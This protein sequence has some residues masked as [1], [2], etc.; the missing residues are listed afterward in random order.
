MTDLPLIR[1]QPGRDKRVAA[2]HPWIFSNEIA[3]TP[4]LREVPLGAPVRVEAANGRALGVGGFNRHALIAVRMLDRSPDAAIDTAFLRRRLASALALRDTLFDRPFYRLVHAEADGLPGL[5]VDRYGDVLVMQSNTALMDRLEGPLCDALQE[6]LDPRAIVLRND[7]AVRGLEGL[8]EEVRVA[9]GA[10]DGP[11]AVEENGAR[12][13]AD[14]LGGQKTG[15]FFDQRDNRAFVARLARGRRL[16]DVYTHTGGFGVQ[17][18]LAGAEAVTLVD[19]SAPS[20]ELAAKAAA[21][22]GVADRVSTARGEAFAELE[23]RGA[24][25]E[26]WPVVV[27]DPPAFVKSK[28]DLAAGARGYAKL[29]RLAARVTERGGFLCAFSCSHHVDPALFAEQVARGLIDAGRTG[30]ILRQSG[31]GPDHP[32]HPLLPESAYLKGIVL[33][34]D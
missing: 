13:E 20:L 12:F 34:L 30:R 32:V 6:L 28:K 22:N 16:L 31:A 14:P 10:V 3:M 29:A 4:E 15:W 26:R 25:G 24:T 5:I 1:L 11:I 7:S 21:A 18:A 8:A 23:R 17:A 9:R 33:Q 27:V 19:R 2:G